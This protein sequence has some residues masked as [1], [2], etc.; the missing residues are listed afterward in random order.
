MQNLENI[1]QKREQ[2]VDDKCICVPKLS[3][4]ILTVNNA[5]TKYFNDIKICGII[6][7]ESEFRSINHICRRYLRFK[8]PIQIE[9][10][11]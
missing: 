11:V 3:A 6:V 4:R 8:G 7:D 1:Q 10:E 2:Y 5:T 9:F